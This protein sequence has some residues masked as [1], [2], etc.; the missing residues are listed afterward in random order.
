MTAGTNGRFPGETGSGKPVLPH[1]TA[2]YNQ[3]H[4]RRV[5]ANCLVFKGM[6]EAGIDGLLV[7]AENKFYSEGD[8]IFSAGQ[9][10]DRLY[11]VDCGSVA[12]GVAAEGDGSDKHLDFDWVGPGEMFGE[13]EVLAGPSFGLRQMD[14]IAL[15]ALSVVVVAGRTVRERTSSFLAPFASL[16]A[17][18]QSRLV[19]A[20]REAAFVGLVEIRLARS[21]QE[22]GRRF[23]RWHGAALFL[24]SRKLTQNRIARMVGADS[25][26]VLETLRSWGE[27]GIVHY[28]KG[29]LAIL[30]PRR[31]AAIA[32]CQPGQ[33]NSFEV[34]ALLGEIDGALASGQNVYA[35]ELALT[36]LKR[37]PLRSD[38]ILQHR[39]I[40][41]TA[42]CGDVAEA[43]RRLQELGLDHHNSE[44]D[45]AALEPRLN[46]DLALAA[47]DPA[48]RQRH[49]ATSALQY[50]AIAE[51]NGDDC[52]PAINAATMFLLAGER[53]QAS[54]WARKVLSRLPKPQTYF[55]HASQGEARLIQGDLRAAG[56]AYRLALRSPDVNPGAIATSRRQIRIIGHA[57]G[58]EVS[59]VLAQAAQG[60]IVHFT[61]HL[62]NP[63]T[64]MAD[65]EVAARRIDRSLAGIDVLW[66]FGSLAA[67]SDI[68]F[69][70]N[71]LERGAKL[72]VVLPCEIDA[73][74]KAS[75]K[76]SGSAWLPR[77]RHCLDE[78][79]RVVVLPWRGVPS[80]RAYA[81][82]DRI[83]M[84][85]AL[86]QA[87]ELEARASQFAVW[88]E[89]SATKGAG[90]A[91]AVAEWIRLGQTSI[92]IPCPWRSAA[93]DAAVPAS[94]AAAPIPAVLLWIGSGTPSGPEADG[95][96]PPTGALSAACPVAEG[97]GWLF[98]SAPA[99]ATAAA[100]I[101][102]HSQWNR[103]A[104][105][106][107]L[108]LAPD[109]AMADWREPLGQCRLAQSLPTTPPG[110]CGATEIF[111]VEALVATGEHWPSTHIGHV[112]CQESMPP[113]P[114]YILG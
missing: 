3:D 106:L 71:I 59:D 66:A 28:H 46:K 68:L 21:L 27:L 93:S 24:P 7:G 113:M 32:A 16:M 60:Q 109:A 70:E 104:Q 75:V 13:L 91:L 81:W 96:P 56:N 90:T 107:L 35:R 30:D 58:L 39:A 57:L 80:M 37:K 33:R 110:T 8:A 84:G 114:L 43:L 79:Q 76:N 45:I 1:S 101:R 99:A 38:P 108:D 29:Q 49:A 18:R 15:S 9:Q 42:R 85:L 44:I 52:Y 5:I 48:A 31:L 83:A 67:G 63:R 87:R 103:M 26:S 2:H 47:S 51:R 86:R 78:A 111:M 40:L 65:L 20:L 62:A 6:T 36:A 4:R 102:Q 77:F 105:R 64:A 61:G 72:T 54:A 98:E 25:R 92:P 55:E 112:P 11:L 82:A 22:Q 12:I 89:G 23:G 53:P 73:F 100:A 94:E 50:A 14:A 41:A 19:A 97:C 74:I 69:S 17:E 88:N 34:T 10:D 95:M